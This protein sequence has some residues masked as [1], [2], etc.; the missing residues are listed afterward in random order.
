MSGPWEK[1]KTPGVQASGPWEKYRNSNQASAPWENFGGS[2][3][4]AAAPQ[5]PT[6]AA[7]AQG[8]DA[9]AQQMLSPD[10]AQLQGRQDGT[11]ANARAVTGDAL[12]AFASRVPKGVVNFVGLPGTLVDM[13][14]DITSWAASNVSQALGGPELNFSV[15]T[16]V[17]GQALNDAIGMDELL[18]EPRTYGGKIAGRVGE[19]VGAAVIPIAGFMG[20]ASRMGTQGAREAPRLL[21][22]FLERA[23]IDPKRFA[24]QESAVATAA[25]IGAGTLDPDQEN[26]LLDLVG[27][28]SGAGIYG[29]GKTLMGAGGNVINA[30]RGDPNY[31]DE[32]VRQHVADILAD[33]ANVRPDASG[34]ADTSDLVSMLL[35]PARREI[36]TVIPGFR[37]SSADVT[38]N[39]GLASL[40]YSR[41]SGQ[42]AGPFNA[43][44]T[45]N[46]AAVESVMRGYEPV[47]TP[48]VFREALQD[49]AD[50]RLSDAAVA[51]M[52]AR[53]VFDTLLGDLTPQTSRSGRGA[54]VREDLENL[55]A[56]ERDKVNRAYSEFD[57][58]ARPVDAEE[59]QGAIASAR[60]ALTTAERSW[61]PEGTL[62]RI[63]A[64]GKSADPEVPPEPVRMR[65]VTSLLSMLG[66]QK[67]AALA[68]PENGGD[69]AASAID[70]VMNA[71]Q[72]FIDARIT[73]DEK[74]A[75]EAAKRANFE[76]MEK[77]RRPG[78]PVAEVLREGVGGRYSVP[79]ENVAS[80]FANRE[81][82]LDELFKLS[83]SPETRG[84]I[85]DE[86][87]SRS[88]G[89]DARSLEKL[90]EQYAAQI[91]RF[92]GLDDELK[93]AAD[94]GRT[95][96]GFGAARTELERD[97]GAPG[98]PGRSVVGKYL[99]Y[100]DEN[101]ERAISAVLAS[102]D[103]A[104]AADELVQF[105]GNNPRALEGARAAFWQK[106]KKETR[107]AEKSADGAQMWRGDWL[108]EFLTE[109]RTAAVAE[110]LY[111]DKPEH[112]DALRAIGAALQ[113]TDLRTRARAPSTSGTAQSVNNVLTPETLQSRVYAYA[114]G[115][116]SGTFLASSIAAVA[117]RRAVRGARADAINRMLDEALLDPNA[118]AFLLEQYNPANRAALA[119]KAKVWLGN[120]ANTFMEV[121]AEDDEPE[122]PVKEW[123]GGGR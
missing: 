31:A 106:L 89:S 111:S 85:R 6:K 42:G 2:T 95:A 18:Y 43:R 68:R 7:L 27:A 41:Q 77:F 23:A 17:S 50:R 14:S 97:L 84:A 70:N 110:R 15:R 119:K 101:A 8:L 78:S 71:M 52:N 20:A 114:R 9:Q 40:E 46:N 34:T 72:R 21:R 22:D 104:A 59:L 96:E 62:D 39:P 121:L 65:E 25:G 69:Y 92:P 45:S 1:F 116:I 83:N 63:E 75:W 94:A 55:L 113:N 82:A 53:E 56:A 13:G 93:K 51:E 49:E 123:A 28:F 19:E 66:Q 108:N 98:R 33:H 24:Q 74:Q 88:R 118:A 29:A 10:D 32:V 5:D 109:P 107:S 3:S 61:I 87:L 47:E 100:G 26:P 112:L 4:A 16:P 12:A 37:P 80:R 35:D 86:I 102:K 67:R 76:K 54:L 115:Q 73:P 64:L 38:A 44:R 117:A 48:G 90:R 36:E 99:Q 11:W 60:E 120:Q 81:T 105:A 57:V 122:D 103:P 58:A 30:I 91:S 79:D